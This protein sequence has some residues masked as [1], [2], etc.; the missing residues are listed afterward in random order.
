[1]GCWVLDQKSPDGGSAEGSLGG[2]KGKT[3]LEVRGHAAE[4]S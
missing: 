4:E 2:Q 1:M 3:S